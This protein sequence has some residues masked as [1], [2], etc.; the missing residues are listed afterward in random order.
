MELEGLLSLPACE[1][2]GLLSLPACELE[3]LLVETLSKHRTLVEKR[4][5]R[6]AYPYCPY[7]F[8]PQGNDRGDWLSGGVVEVD[9]A[10]RMELW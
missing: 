7:S 10:G 6:P 1:L 8:S 4:G 5:I 2:E 9:A 3:G